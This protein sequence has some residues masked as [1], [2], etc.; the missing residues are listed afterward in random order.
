MERDSLA[1]DKCVAADAT[2]SKALR[3]V[4][5]VEAVAAVF[6]VGAGVDR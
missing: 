3:S 4:P 6:L 1:L 5:D 2:A